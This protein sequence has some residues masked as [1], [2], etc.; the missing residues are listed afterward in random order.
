MDSAKNRMKMEN[1]CITKSRDDMDSMIMAME[2]TSSMSMNKRVNLPAAKQSLVRMRE[3]TKTCDE[4]SA[5]T[6]KKTNVP[7][8]KVHVGLVPLPNVMAVTDKGRY[9]KKHQAQD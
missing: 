6:S 4:E 8:T 7:N 9:P 1:K 3:P 5:S 2:R